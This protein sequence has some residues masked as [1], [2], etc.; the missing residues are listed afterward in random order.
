MNGSCYV[1]IRFRKISKKQK[2]LQGEGIPRSL[3]LMNR[4]TVTRPTGSQPSVK[5]HV[6]R[7]VFDSSCDAILCNF[8]NPYVIICGIRKR[9]QP[10]SRLEITSYE[11]LIGYP[12]KNN[13][14]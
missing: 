10:W 13:E 11:A 14:T 1:Q 5:G 12:C 2:I 3:V 7:Y 8:C 6:R 9:L 4:G